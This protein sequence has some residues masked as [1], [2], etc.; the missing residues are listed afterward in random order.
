LLGLGDRGRAESPIGTGAIGVAQ[1]APV[2]EGAKDVPAGASNDLA[3][4][5]LF[6]HA[7]LHLGSFHCLLEAQE[8]THRFRHG[9]KEGVGCHRH[10]PVQERMAVRRQPPPWLTPHAGAKEAKEAK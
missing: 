4:A 5:E 8:T 6:A 3:V 2:D 7:A 1:G 9:R 10:T